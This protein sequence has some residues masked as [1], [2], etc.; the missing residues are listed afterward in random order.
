MKGDYVVAAN[1]AERA[2][3]IVPTWPIALQ[4]FGRALYN[5]GELRLAQRA[6]SR[7]VHLDPGCEELWTEDLLV[8]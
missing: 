7:A 5:L 8:S 2:H 1:L 4:T 6:F 3:R